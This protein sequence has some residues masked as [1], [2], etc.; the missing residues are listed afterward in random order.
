MNEESVKIKISK[1]FGNLYRDR[2]VLIATFNNSRQ[3]L[4]GA[5]PDFYPPG[6]VRL[7][8][9][10]VDEGE[11]IEDAAHRELLEEI[12]VDVRKDKIRLITK[13]DI[14][15]TDCSGNTYN[16]DTYLTYADIGSV[17]VNPGDDVKQIVKYESRDLEKLID[18]YKRLSPSLW[19]K[20]LEGEFSWHD[21][22]QVYS[23]IHDKGLDLF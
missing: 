17:S 22:A 9:G 15:A 2:C 8:G 7:L 18:N 6:I 1:P 3:L 14:Q 11:S 23:V 12:G 21:Y 10:G 16:N 19:Y 5:K 4:L 13:F 20:G